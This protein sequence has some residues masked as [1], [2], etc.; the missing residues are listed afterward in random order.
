MS[1]TRQSSQRGSWRASA[2]NGPTSSGS[3]PVAMGSSRC[4]VG[5]EK[6]VLMGSCRCTCRRGPRVPPA[7]HPRGPGGTGESLPER[8]LVVGAVAEL[9]LAHDDAAQKAVGRMLVGEGDPTE[10]LHGVVGD[11][12]GAARDVGLGHRGGL[13]GV[14]G[15]VVEAG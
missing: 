13:D 8:A 9:A 6:D 2:S 7:I 1:A 11:L 12:S 4:A 14:A 3:A 5:S 15:A 10:H